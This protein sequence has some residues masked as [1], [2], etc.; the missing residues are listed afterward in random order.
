MKCAELRYAA[1]IF[2]AT[3]VGQIALAEHDL[4]PGPFEPKWKS[5]AAN[6]H[7]PDWFRDAKFGIWAHWTA[8]CVPEQG[9]WYARQMYIQGSPQYEH[10]LTTYGHPADSGF[11]ELDHL[12]QAEKWDPERLMQLYKAAGAKYFVALANHHDNFDCYDSKYHEWNSVRVGPKQ[13]IV[14]RWAQGRARRRDCGSACRTIR[15]TPGTGSRRRT[16]T[17]ARGRGRANG[18]MRSSSPRPTARASGGK[19]SIRN[20]STRDRTWSCPTD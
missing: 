14:G 1:A 12:W 18:T 13:D 4:A 17:T 11:M 6:Y 16:A 5:L 20:C 3:L 9:D 10:H 8:Q 19:A 15:P 7:C 2:T